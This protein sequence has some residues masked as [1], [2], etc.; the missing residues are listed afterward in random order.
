MRQNEGRQEKRNEH[1]NIIKKEIKEIGEKRKHYGGK[2]KFGGEK[3][4]Q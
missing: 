4:E 2:K 1:E 3:H